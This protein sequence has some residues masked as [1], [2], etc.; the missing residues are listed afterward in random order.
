VL[1][2]LWCKYDCTNILATAVAC[3]TRINPTTLDAYDKALLLVDGV[4]KPTQIAPHRGLSSNL[5][6][7][8]HENGIAAALPAAY[9]CTLV[10]GNNNS[11]V[12]LSHICFRSHLLHPGNILES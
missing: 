10:V 1:I 4:Y 8:A 11:P 6:V 12:S 5:T 3:I 9:Y 2:Q 7:L